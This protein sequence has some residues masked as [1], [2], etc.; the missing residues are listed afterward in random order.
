MIGLDI[1][2]GTYWQLFLQ[3]SN[4]TIV[5]TLNDNR[6]GSHIQRTGTHDLIIIYVPSKNVCKNKSTPLVPWSCCYDS[7]CFPKITLSLYA[8][9]NSLV[10]KKRQDRPLPPISV[11]LSI[12]CCMT[13]VWWFLL[14]PKLKRKRKYLSKKRE[15]NQTK[16]IF[17]TWMLLIPALQ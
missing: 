4:I 2:M 3:L 14:R 1:N 9:Q 13:F 7:I 5:F 6:Q 11:S 16:G 15:M 17:L 10:N 8:L 12:C